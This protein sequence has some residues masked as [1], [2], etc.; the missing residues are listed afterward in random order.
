[1]A[2]NSYNSCSYSCDNDGA[3]AGLGIALGLGLFSLF[4]AAPAASRYNKRLLKRQAV[5]ALIVPTRDG[6]RLGL[7]FR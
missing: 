4:D 5:G 7:S 3:Y 1:V 6:L 2:I